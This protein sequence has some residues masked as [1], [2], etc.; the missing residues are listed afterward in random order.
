M[1][2]TTQFQEAYERVE[3]DLVNL[4]NLTSDLAADI[5][6]LNSKALLLT[7]LTGGTINFQPCGTSLREVLQDLEGQ[8]EDI[9]YDGE[10]KEPVPLPEPI[11]ILFS[12]ERTKKIF[13]GFQA[14]M[15]LSHGVAKLEKRHRD[16]EGVATEPD[17][18]T[19]LLQMHSMLSSCFAAYISFS[20]IEPGFAEV[21]DRIFDLAHSVDLPIGDTYVN[22]LLRRARVKQALHQ[23]KGD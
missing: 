17:L 6:N 5:A 3:Q 12:P 22:E 14:M 18:R 20:K 8:L 7:S 15:E 10:V 19:E 11:K 13:D 9:D 1:A 2:K 4:S 23:E 16:A 21:L